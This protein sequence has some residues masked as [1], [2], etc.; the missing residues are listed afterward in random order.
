[1]ADKGK[2]RESAPSAMSI[3]DLARKSTLVTLHEH[4][5]N[6]KTSKEDFEKLVADE[7][8]KLRRKSPESL[9]QIRLDIEEREAAIDKGYMGKDKGK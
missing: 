7:F 5:I 2:E 3:K 4:G 1:M 8:A 6:T 9:K